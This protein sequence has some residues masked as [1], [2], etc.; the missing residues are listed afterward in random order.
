HLHRT[1]VA[2]ERPVSVGEILP[3]RPSDNGD[4]VAHGLDRVLPPALDERAADEGN[5]SERVERA[6]LADGVGD[7]DLG[8]FTGNGSKR[9]LCKGEA[10]I[11]Q[12]LG[13]GRAALGVA[14]SDDRA[15]T[16]EVARKLAVRIRDDFLLAFVRAGGKKYRPTAERVLETLELAQVHRR[17]R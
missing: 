12:S 17:G 2:Q 5:G 13:N 15:E 1:L 10:K 3:V 4:T 14:R 6:E 16:F 9:P 11:L 8:T 7:V